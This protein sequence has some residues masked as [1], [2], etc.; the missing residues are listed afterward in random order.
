[1]TDQTTPETTLE[2]GGPEAP[3]SDSPARG[4]SQ[5]VLGPNKRILICRVGTRVMFVNYSKIGK[6]KMPGSE[7]ESAV[8][9][10]GARAIKFEP[11]PIEG[12]PEA[13]NGGS[14][15][16]TERDSRACGLDYKALCERIK[17]NDL[18]GQDYAF[19]DDRRAAKGILD[20]MHRQAT[21]EAALRAEQMAEGVARSNLTLPSQ[22]A[23][24]T[25]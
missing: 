22:R 7:L 20:R 1:M 4:G 10:D 23:V 9:E 6:V 11:G 19:L 13:A 12:A 16:V 24:A 25:R 18:Y 8:Y 2:G 21:K 3:A 14:Y 17:E 5:A 15:L